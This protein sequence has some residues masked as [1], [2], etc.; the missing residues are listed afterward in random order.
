MIGLSSFNRNKT[1]FGEDAHEFRPERWLEKEIDKESHLAK[2]FTVWSPILSFL[3]G[4]RGCIGYR[5][6][7][8]IR[9][10]AVKTLQHCIQLFWKSKRFLPP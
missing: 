6:G 4:P 2:G 8:F 10:G 9:M 3:G 7:K 1:I 5:F